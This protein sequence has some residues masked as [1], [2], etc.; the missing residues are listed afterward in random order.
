MQRCHLWAVSSLVICLSGQLCWY[1]VERMAD[2]GA[3]YAVGAFVTPLAMLYLAYLTVVPLLFPAIRISRVQPLGTVL[4]NKWLTVHVSTSIL[5]MPAL[6][7]LL[8][9]L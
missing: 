4:Q 5:V 2:A 8:P 6:H 1:I 9:P 7:W 3:V